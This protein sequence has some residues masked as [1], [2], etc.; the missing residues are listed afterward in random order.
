MYIVECQ[1]G[2]HIVDV[3]GLDL[4]LLEQLLKNNVVFKINTGG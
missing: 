1:D 4:F 3:Q 2:K